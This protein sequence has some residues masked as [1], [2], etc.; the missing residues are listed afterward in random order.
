MAEVRGSET[1]GRVSDV[2]MLFIDGPGVMGVTDMARSLGLSK[3]VVHRTLATLVDKG[4]L[5]KDPRTRGYELG[6][7]AA[8]LGARALRGSS[9]RAAAQPWMEKLHEITRETV[10]ISARVP[11]GRVYLGQVESA[12]EIKMTVELGRRFPLYA[13]SS[14]M[15]ILAFMPEAEQ[16]EYLA[17]HP[18]EAITNRTVTDPDTLRQR[19]AEV[20][21]TGIAQSEGERQRGAGSVAAPIFSMDG[22]VE[23]AL[24]VCGPGYRMDQEARDRVVP[25]LTRA[26]D[27]VSQSLSWRGGLPSAVR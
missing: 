15:C 5:T 16:E 8:S 23:G 13:G 17:A 11:G 19:L 14:S 27:E 10:T 18:P 7:S 12:L 9:L 24:S 25:D 22:R 2:L 20:R 21:R 4:F 1:A 3:T 26:A 6:P